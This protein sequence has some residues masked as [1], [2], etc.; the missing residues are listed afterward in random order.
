MDIRKLLKDAI[1]VHEQLIASVDLDPD[2]LMELS[3]QRNVLLHQLREQAGDLMDWAEHRQAFQE[4]LA[5]EAEWNQALRK[6]F[7]AVRAEL[8]AVRRNRRNL[9]L[10]YGEKHC[11]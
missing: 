9:A 5:R 6:Q 4:L 2:E 11:G 1:S 3:T 7:G 10:G 8:T